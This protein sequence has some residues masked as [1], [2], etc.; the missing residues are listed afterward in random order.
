MTDLELMRQALDALENGAVRW[1]SDRLHDI[2]VAIYA[3]RARLAQPEPEPVVWMYQNK[4]T[5]EVRFQKHMRDFVD[6]GQTYETPL[7]ARE[8]VSPLKDNMNTKYNPTENN[9]DYERGFIDGM[10]KQM[11]S[12]VDKAVNSIAKPEPSVEPVAWRFDQAKYRENDL[13]GRQ[14]AFNVFS[15]TKPYM[16]EMVRNVTPLYTAPPQREWKYNPMTGEPLIDGWPLYSGLP[17]REWQGL[18]DEDL[19]VC[20]EDGVLLARYWE[21]KLREKNHV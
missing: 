20:D 21:A 17:Q 15:Q 4:S 16:D 10:Q 3:L 5:N 13:R 18:T 8:W 14:W 11:Q 1:K 19:S 2:D 7:Y 6:H 12:S 9:A